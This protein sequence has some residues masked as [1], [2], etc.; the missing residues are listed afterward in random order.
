MPQEGMRQNI[1]FFT[2]LKCGNRNAKLIGPMGPLLP[3]S[4]S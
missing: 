2:L 3:F 4:F 1:M